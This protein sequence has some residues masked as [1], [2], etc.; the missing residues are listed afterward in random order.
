MLFI[1]FHIFVR[2][3]SIQRY[4][5]I[6]DLFFRK[7]T[8]CDCPIPCT[9]FVYD[10]TVTYADTSTYDGQQF[11]RNSD[12]TRLL[13]KY[14]HARDTVQRVDK[15]I[16]KSD[17]TLMNLF[18]EEMD[19]LEVEMHNAAKDIEDCTASLW[20]EMK[21]LIERTNFHKSW[22]LDKVHYMIKYNF[23]RGWTV[24]EERT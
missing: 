21:D 8:K 5:S 14:I 17:R 11:L 2:E 15:A 22:G 10:A 9:R 6:S 3:L 4:I 24:R 19:E 12:T 23:I 20:V 16:A 7:E 13:Q 1:Q 18:N